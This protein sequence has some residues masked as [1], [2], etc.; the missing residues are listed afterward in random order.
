MAL[1]QE[2]SQKFLQKLSPQQ[3]QFIKL[4]QLN[5]QDFEEKVSQEL[6]D[7]PALENMEGAD[8]SIDFRPNEDRPVET[9]NEKSDETKHQCG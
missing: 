1:K 2:L 6:L 7:N 9:R 8:D 5:T 3:I 4:L